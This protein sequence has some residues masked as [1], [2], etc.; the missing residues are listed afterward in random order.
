HISDRKRGSHIK[1]ELHKLNQLKEFALNIRK[2]FLRM[3][4]RSKVLIYSTAFLMTGA[5]IF[6]VYEYIDQK[7]LRDDAFLLHGD[8]HIIAGSMLEY[9]SSEFSGM[10][11]GLPFLQP[12]T[13]VSTVSSFDYQVKEGDTLSEIS[14]TYDINVGTL[15]S[16]NKIENVRRIWVGANL[17]I[18][19]TDGLPY[20]VKNGDSLE[21]IASDHRVPLNNILDANNLD[22][23]VITAG[24]QLFIPGAEIS[25]YDYKK[26][27]GT[28]FVYPAS[29]RLS[30]PFGYRSDPFTGVRRMHYGVDLSN[31]VGTTV[32]ATMSGTVIV[33]G[34]QPLGYGNYI[35]IRHKRGFQS[36]YGHLSKILVRNGQ[37]ISQG[38]K[39]GEMGNSGRSTGSHLHF[40]LYKNNVPVDP[41]RGYLYR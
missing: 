11:S 28:L 4:L 33:I 25:E 36:L 15:I 38:Q 6:S 17:K 10:G 26:A 7:I 5:V 23:D 12:G 21:S 16:Y 40:S 37:R 3:D 29:G 27:T 2:A 13:V 20:I 8:T 41:L 24:D 18:P 9:A 14:K 19:D 22:S 31:R 39:L 35:V 34:H 32:K 30:S 1:T